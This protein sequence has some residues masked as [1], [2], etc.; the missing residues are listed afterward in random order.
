MLNDTWYEIDKTLSEECS[1]LKD[2][3]TTKALMVQLKLSTDNLRKL[4]AIDKQHSKIRD[5][6]KQG[7]RHPTFLLDDREILY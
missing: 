5:Q 4:Q 7:Q 3:T 6:L 1:P 2:L